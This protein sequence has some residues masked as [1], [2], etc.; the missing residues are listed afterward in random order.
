MA[1]FHVG[2]AVILNSVAGLILLAVVLAVV[3]KQVIVREEAYLERAFG[4]EYLAYKDRVGRW[5]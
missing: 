5:L 1:I 2:L 4:H 3:Q